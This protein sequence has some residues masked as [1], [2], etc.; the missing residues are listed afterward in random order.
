MLVFKCLDHILKTKIA[1][2]ALLA[3]ENIV[4]NQKI[5][6]YIIDDNF[7]EELKVFCDFLELFI[8]FI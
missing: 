4:L 7:W 1:I 8:N 3:E 2:K 5:K 6:N